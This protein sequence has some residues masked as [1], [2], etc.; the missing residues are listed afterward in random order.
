M[1]SFWP[2]SFA[3]KEKKKKDWDVIKQSN[4]ADEHDVTITASDPPAQRNFKW[5][6]TLE[7][8]WSNPSFY[9]WE[10]KGPESG[11]RPQLQGQ[12]EGKKKAFRLPFKCKSLLMPLN[13]NCEKEVV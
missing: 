6:E 4:V 11:P 10:D 12:N 1:M 9:R 8:V 5:K 2:K 13:G 7:T 3:L